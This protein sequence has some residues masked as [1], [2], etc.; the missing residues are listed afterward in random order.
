LPDEVRVFTSKKHSRDRRPRYY[1]MVLWLAL[2]FLEYRQ[3]TQHKAES[4]PV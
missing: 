2:A 1:S 4:L 3:A